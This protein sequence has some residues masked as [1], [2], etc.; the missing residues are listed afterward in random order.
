MF[1]GII[2]DVGVVREV[3]ERQA[4]LRFRIGCGYDTDTIAIGASIACAGPCLTVVEKGEDS[5]GAFFDVD[6]STETLARTT[7][8]R[9]VPG[10]RVNL[11][12]AMRAG[13]EFGGHMVS[14]HIDAV[15]EVT[16][17]RDEGDM[18]RFTVVAPS[19]V[20]RYVA[21]KGSVTLDGTSLTVNDVGEDGFGVMIVPHTL[22]VT[23]WGERSSGDAI[24]LEVDLVARYLERLVALRLQEERL[25]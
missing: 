21:P 14:G 19:S 6:V 15:A 12:R 13:D 9:W 20:L 5:H 23:S 1:T 16:S 7:A 2:S 24:N 4:G 11:E 17:R 22:A 3:R 25:S 18:A 8:G 10:T